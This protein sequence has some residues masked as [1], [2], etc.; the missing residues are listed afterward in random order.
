MDNLT[1]FARDAMKARLR[2]LGSQAALGKEIGL[3][4]PYISSLLAHENRRIKGGA[5]VE[6]LLTRWFSGSHDALMAAA[7]LGWADW[8]GQLDAS[9]ARHVAPVRTKPTQPAA[10]AAIS[11]WVFEIADELIDQGHEPA[12]VRDVVWSLA[13]TDGPHQHSP[14]RFAT[15]ASLLLSGPA[16]ARE[17]GVVAAEAAKKKPGI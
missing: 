3:E 8:R 10:P 12:S 1:R 2:E 6:W 13:K 16:I 9:A 15:R 11:G 5:I 17:S 7:D 4:P 14:V